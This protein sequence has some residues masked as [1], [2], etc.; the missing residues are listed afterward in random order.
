M[1][2]FTLGSMYWV[3]PNHSPEDFR[4][5]MRRVKE[6]RIRLLRIMIVWE[7]VETERDKYDFS[8]YDKA[9]RAAEEAG[10]G[11]MGSFL[12]YLPFHL[13]VEQEKNGASDFDKRYACLDRPE[14]R[15]ALGRFMSETVRRYRSSPALKMW[16]LWNEPTDTPCQCPHSL[17]KFAGWLKRKYVDFE[18]LK[19]AWAGEY[20]V[21]PPSLPHDMDSLN[22]EWLKYVFSFPLKGRDTSV[23]LDWIEFQTENAAEHLAFLND[24]VK[25]NDPDHETHSNPNA[26]VCNPLLMGISPW[27]L[28]KVQDSISGSVHPHDMLAWLESD[29]DHYPRAML[30]VFDLVRS[31]ADGRDAW[32]GEYQAGST[33]TKHN[34]YTPRGGDI[35]SSLYHAYARGLRGLVFWEWQSWRHGAFETAEFSLRNPSDGGPTERSE[36][37][38]EFGVFLERH[39]DALAE[40]APERPQVAILHSMDQ[41]ALD[42]LM[43]GVTPG[44]NVNQHYLAAFTC[45][46][47][48]AKAGIPCDFITEDQLSEDVLS[49]YKVLFLPYVRII[50]P[51]TAAKLKEFVAAGGALWADCRCG[52]LDKHLCLRKRVPGNGLDEVFGCREIDEVA[53]RPADML[54]LKDG[55][56]LKPYREIQRLRAA[57]NAEVLAECGGYPAAVRHHYGRGTAELWGTYL[58]ANRSEVLAEM[59]PRFAEA[60]GAE[61]PVRIR[62]GKDIWVSCCRGGNVLLAVFTSLAKAPQQITAVLPVSAG[63]ILTPSGAAWGRDG[64][65]L[66]IEPYETAA[67]LIRASAA[68][69]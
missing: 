33:Y 1:S 58:T 6:N 40:L 18:G 54:I 23:R 43:E 53:P 68:H 7:Y 63:E 12:F 5:D 2:D 61:V 27:K 36:A 34:A 65:E 66:R 55:S 45:H 28:A 64:L 8:L 41:F 56:R 17:E 16:N 19:K 37:A 69:A 52:F 10:I 48:L 57:E 4:E 14:I 26:T 29:Q 42:L 67:V 46:Q 62:S 11:V 35:S 22:A 31:W 9:F 51:E 38:K 24:L 39:H 59:L 49:R 32:I 25:R 13:L 30:S 21:H 60:H 50:A 15:E 44:R 20:I 47:A 3:N